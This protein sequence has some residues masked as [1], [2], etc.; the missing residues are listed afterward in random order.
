MTIRHY[1]IALFIEKQ[2]SLYY[3]NSVVFRISIN[4]HVS[5][6]NK[7]SIIN[8]PGMTFTHQCDRSLSLDLLRCKFSK[9][10]NLK[11]KQRLIKIKYVFIHVLYCIFSIYYTQLK[12]K[13]N[14]SLDK[15]VIQCF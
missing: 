2:T 1:V 4:A 3:I 10:K 13:G 11:P 6:K 5:F 8:L 15:L 12:D 14:N 7:F 9:R